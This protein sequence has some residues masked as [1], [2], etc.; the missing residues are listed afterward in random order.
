MCCTR[1]VE[2][3]GQLS[4]QYLRL[5]LSAAL[6]LQGCVPDHSIDCGKPKANTAMAVCGSCCPVWP[7]SAVSNP[8]GSACKCVQAT[9]GKAVCALLFGC[10][11]C[12]LVC[13]W[14]WLYTASK[15]PEVE[16]RYKAFKSPLSVKITHTRQAVMLVE[17]YDHFSWWSLAC[18]WVVLFCQLLRISHAFLQHI[19]SIP[20]ATAILNV[21]GDY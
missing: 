13:I 21:A 10:L 20:N 14:R 7:D 8:A 5:R 12:L 15:L 9:K 6:G 11:P 17:L 4:L 1:F 16:I 2:H 19:G 18:C 3:V